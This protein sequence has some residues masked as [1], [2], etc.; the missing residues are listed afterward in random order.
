MIDPPSSPF[1]LNDPYS[2]QVREL[3]V[4]LG[5]RKGDS[6]LL[7]D[8][9]VTI[10]P[11]ILLTVILELVG[12][13]GTVMSPVFR[14]ER[15]Q[16]V[17]QTTLM[18]LPAISS[19][20]PPINLNAIQTAIWNH[21]HAVI[22]NHPVIGY[23]A[24][25]HNAEFLTEKAPFHYPFGEKSPLS[26][27]HQLN[28]KFLS[29]GTSSGLELISPLAEVWTDIP[30][31]RRSVHVADLN[32][33]WHRMSGGIFCKEG[34][35]RL[36]PILR[37]ARIVRKVDLVDTEWRIGHIQNIVSMAIEVL[38]GDAEGLLCTNPRCETCMEARTMVKDS[39]ALP[40][41]ESRI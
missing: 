16:V 5:L 27:L 11:E 30:Y 36:T 9:S 26:R 13:T 6:I 25:G 38:K 39:R 12:E 15:I 34:Y 3:L 29:I 24:V 21:P 32:G 14:E 35:G 7:S 28:A 19:S 23:A 33:D 1:S 4:M 20:D 37:Q 31:S 8:N 22:T 2:N 10:N 40:A 17:L 41:R 18:S